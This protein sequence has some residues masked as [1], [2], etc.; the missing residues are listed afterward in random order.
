MALVEQEELSRFHVLGVQRARRRGRDSRRAAGKQKAV[1]EQ[2]DAHQPGPVRRPGN[3]RCIKRT[4]AQLVDQP[5]GPRFAHA[6]VERKVART[7]ERQRR[8]QEVRRDR[9]DHPD[10]EP[11]G[12][13]AVPARDL[14]D[15]FH[16]G[17]DTPCPAHHFPAGGRQHRL[18]A[19]ALDEPR[20]ERRLEFADLHGERRLADV[21]RRGG[22][23]EMPLFRQSR[24]IAQLLQ[25]HRH[26]PF[27]SIR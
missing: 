17:Q 8:G 22:P 11:A 23:A 3:H 19:A 26:N 6:E 13:T 16:L 15:L 9:G 18:P 21:D 2:R 1:L 27:L 5:L 24:Q 20:P 14:L 10:A 7:Q 12:E 25:G 4:L